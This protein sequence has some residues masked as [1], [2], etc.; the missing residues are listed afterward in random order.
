MTHKTKARSKKVEKREGGALT[1]SNPLF[2]IPTIARRIKTL[3]WLPIEAMGLFRESAR[4]L[5]I[6]ISG[7]LWCPV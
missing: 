5:L 6:S 3:L 7:F 4:V 1:H 2:C